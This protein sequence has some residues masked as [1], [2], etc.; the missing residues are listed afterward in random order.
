MRFK[1]SPQQTM[2]CCCPVV[3]G[4]RLSQVEALVPTYLTPLTPDLNNLDS[5][6]SKYNMWSWY[7][8]NTFILVAPSVLAYSTQAL[9]YLRSPATRLFDQ[10]LVQ[11]TTKKISKLRIN[12]PSMDRWPVDSPHKGPVMR[13]A[14]PCMS[15]HYMGT[16]LPNQ[17][18]SSQSGTDLL[19]WII[20]RKRVWYALSRW[21][22]MERPMYSR[23]KWSF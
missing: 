19:R 4:L 22:S 1:H 20:G 23:E 6:K 3:N 8:L 11:L 13:E 16:R 17:A 15:W 12:G 9:W 10:Q 21:K 14:C 2:W 18:H 5:V 7:L